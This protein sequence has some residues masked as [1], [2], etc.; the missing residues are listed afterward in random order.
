[1]TAIVAAFHP[2][3]GFIIASDGR[4]LDGLTKKIVS[5]CAQKVYEIGHPEC[6]LLFGWAGA[7]S[8]PTLI[9][10][11]FDFAASMLSVIKDMERLTYASW[12]AFVGEIRC[13]LYGELVGC[14]AG[15]R[16]FSENPDL[17]ECFASCL[18]LG[19]FQGEPVQATIR[20]SHD[21]GTLRF[22]DIVDLGHLG[23]ETEFRHFCGD[24]PLFNEMVKT[25]PNSLGESVDLASR[26]IAE[27]AVR[28]QE[29][30]GKT[31]ILKLPHLFN[32]PK[33]PKR[34]PSIT[35]RRLI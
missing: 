16:L 31:Q 15:L 35:P 5:D 12:D 14:A 23:N 33:T 26:Y 30:G 3:S 2:D 29:Y 9:C 10:G 34:I 1:M 4:R 22:P 7:T 21:A 32:Y 28:S 24:E 13:G 8:V 6:R 18:L 17:N 27:C 25:V 19:Y 11:P 20:F